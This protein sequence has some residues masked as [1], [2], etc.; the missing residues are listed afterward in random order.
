MGLDIL[1]QKLSL[2]DISAFGEISEILSLYIQCF[3][4]KVWMRSLLQYL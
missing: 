3:L 2:L 1:S 4:A